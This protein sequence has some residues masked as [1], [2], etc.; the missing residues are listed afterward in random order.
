MDGHRSDDLKPYV[1]KTTDYGKTW[2]SVVGNLPMF[3][4]VQVI[5]EDPKNPNLLF[6]GTDFG[7]FVTLD[8][9]KTWE[10]FMND[11]PTVRTDE[12]LIHPR[13]GDLIVASH[14]RGLFIADDITAL[15]QMTPAAQAADAVLFDIRPAI[16]YVRVMTGNMQTGGQR[17]WSAPSAPRGTAISYYLKAPAAGPVALTIT[18]ACGGTQTLAASNKTG[19]NRI[20]YPAGGNTGGR[21]QGGAAM[22]GL[23]N[24]P[25]MTGATRDSMITWLVANGGID[26]FGGGRGN[27]GPSQAGGCNGGRGGG[28]SMTPGWY[29]AK[30]SVNGRDYT[31]SFQIIEDKWAGDRWAVD[32]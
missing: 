18:D 7:L 25:T 31:K 10:K 22:A 21:R 8:Q 12:I 2:S 28:A 11:Y 30:L 19:I 26:A 4:N 23:A 15:Q 6:V 1:F 29:T 27:A 24:L 5:R 16:N 20:Q 32:R 3:G 13:D 17:D 9:G 14:G